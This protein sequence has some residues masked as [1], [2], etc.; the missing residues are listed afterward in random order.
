MSLKN[1]MRVNWDNVSTA[2]S[3]VNGAQSIFE[4]WLSFSVLL[5]I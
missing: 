1:V 4:K 2:S 3:L 5:W